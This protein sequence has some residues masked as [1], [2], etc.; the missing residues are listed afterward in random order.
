MFPRF[1]CEINWSAR[2]A[3]ACGVERG[4]RVRGL[5]HIPVRQ[6]VEVRRKEGIVGVGEDVPGVARGDFREE[7]IAVSDHE[8]WLVCG[9]LRMEDY[10]GSL[11][12]AADGFYA[13]I[14]KGIDGPCVLIGVHEI[15]A[16]LGGGEKVE[17][18]L[19]IC[20]YTVD[21][22]G[23]EEA[24]EVVVEAVNVERVD[25]GHFIACDAFM[26]ADDAGFV[27]FG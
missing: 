17:E 5:E 8:P 12:H 18:E 27:G 20:F 25:D 1:V 7:I 9:Q 11:R 10:L 15:P 3:A 22:A 23:E 6:D 16:V 14:T 21:A 24:V 13:E 19:R 2:D 4:V 26:F